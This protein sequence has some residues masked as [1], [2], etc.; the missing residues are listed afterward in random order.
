MA[1]ESNKEEEKECYLYYMPN[2]F[3][4]SPPYNPNAKESYKL[5]DIRLVIFMCNI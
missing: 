1:V 4:I 3:G 2:G 5:R